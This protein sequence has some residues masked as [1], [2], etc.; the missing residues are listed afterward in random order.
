MSKLHNYWMKHWSSF[1]YKSDVGCAP[2]SHAG[3]MATT[4]P[5]HVCMQQNVNF[6]RA[7]LGL[8]SVCFPYGTLRQRRVFY[9]CKQQHMPF[10]YAVLILR[11]KVLGH[12][13]KLPFLSRSGRDKQKQGYR[14][15]KELM[16]AFWERPFVARVCKRHAKITTITAIKRP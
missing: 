5:S 3:S 10:D 11:V 13:F 6:E 14:P 4:K 8:V 16:C 1:V 15:L 12:S 7:H 2:P 9:E